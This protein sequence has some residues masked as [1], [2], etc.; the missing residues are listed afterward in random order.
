VTLGAPRIE[1][2]LRAAGAP[3]T[4]AEIGWSDEL[5][6]AALAHARAIRDRYTF[7]DLVADLDS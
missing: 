1:A 5:F 6:T 2:I 4:P 7:L 3:T